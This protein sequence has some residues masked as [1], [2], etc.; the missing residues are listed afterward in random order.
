MITSCE[1]SASGSPVSLQ[2]E[3]EIDPGL[4]L[5]EVVDF[6]GSRGSAGLITDEINQI[7]RLKSELRQRNGRGLVSPSSSDAELKRFGWP[8]RSP[9]H[10]LRPAAAKIS[11][12]RQRSR[13]LRLYPSQSERSA[14]D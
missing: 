5:G 8:M 12:S 10:L 3:S 4:E 14:C 11:V 2:P 6:L 7:D 1:A 13:D 9:S